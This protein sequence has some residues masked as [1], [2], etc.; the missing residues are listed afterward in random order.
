MSKTVFERGQRVMKAWFNAMQN[1][2]F[3][4]LDLDGHY[5]RL[6][7]DALSNEPGNIKSEF[8]GY[9]MPSELPSSKAWWFV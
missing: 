1:I 9:G 8:Y 4:D 2:K 6:D 7:D 5:P 3:D